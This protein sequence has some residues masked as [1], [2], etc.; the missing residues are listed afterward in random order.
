MG[1][2]VTYIVLSLLFDS[3]SYPI[4]GRHCPSWVRWRRCGS[5]CWTALRSVKEIEMA[6]SF[7][8]YLALLLQLQKCCNCYVSPWIR[9]E[10]PLWARSPAAKTTKSSWWYWKR[11]DQ[12]AMATDNQFRVHPLRVTDPQW[13]FPVGRW[14]RVCPLWPPWCP[15]S[16]PAST[17]T[18]NT[19]PNRRA[20]SPPACAC[21]RAWLCAWRARASVRRERARL[22]C[23]LLRDWEAAQWDFR[24]SGKDH[25]GLPT[26]W[27]SDC[28]GPRELAVRKPRTHA[29]T[30]SPFRAAAVGKPVTDRAA[31]TAY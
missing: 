19:A 3:R 8:V 24:A 7:S 20:T 2:C 21:V 15:R 16:R 31:R 17:P 30:H 4:S 9:L 26:A 6:S 1:K 25:G 14:G 28:E 23:R 18:L 10:M 27:V 29:R 13:L 12:L 11:L 5:G 22:I